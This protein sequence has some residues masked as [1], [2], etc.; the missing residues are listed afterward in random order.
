MVRSS[1]RLPLNA[2]EYVRLA[3][4]IGK[5]WQHLRNR[6]SPDI[7]NA[8]ATLL[9]EI[10]HELLPCDGFSVSQNLNRSRYDIR[11]LATFLREVAVRP[12]ARI[13]QP[14]ADYAAG[15]CMNFPAH[16]SE[17]IDGFTQDLSTADRDDEQRAIDDKLSVK[18]TFLHL[19]TTTNAAEPRRTMSAPPG[20]CRSSPP[21]AKP[22][23]F[24]IGSDS[25]D[26]DDVFDHVDPDETCK[27]ELQIDI[28][29]HVCDLTLAFARL[30][31]C[32]DDCL[33]C[34][35]LE[36][37]SPCSVLSADS[38][39]INTRANC[40]AN[41]LD[42]GCTWETD[43]RKLNYKIDVSL[44]MLRFLAHVA[45][46]MCDV[47]GLSFDSV[48]AFLASIDDDDLCD[49]QEEY[50]LLF[51]ADAVEKE[52]LV[53]KEEDNGW[54]SAADPQGFWS[55]SA[56]SKERLLSSLVTEYPEK[57]VTFERMCRSL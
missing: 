12:Q 8:W 19:D 55:I 49:L 36:E 9:L 30:Q 37:Y 17:R 47:Q 56:G 1:C 41:E 7:K 6:V 31:E 46:H 5:H 44:Y 57:Q 15:S 34:E 13:P 27:L 10:R 26:E 45:G 2:D 53:V 42:F 14:G 3:G 29:Q 22:S 40:M 11:M 28:A 16:R 25:D 48:V 50:G 35:C 54:W 4:H 51:F 23:M 24:Y 39:G 21:A 32:L 20:F 33:V 43:M 52:T 38:Q 18:N